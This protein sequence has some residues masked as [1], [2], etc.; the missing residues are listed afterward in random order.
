MPEIVIQQTARAAQKLAFCYL[1]GEPFENAPGRNNH[2][3]HIPPKQLFA[4][5]DRNFPIKVA[6][7]ESCNNCLSN[8][9]EVIGQLVAVVHGKYATPE[10]LKLEFETVRAETTGN[11]Y[12]GVTG[13]NVEHEVIRWI[14][15]FH[16]ALYGEF[17]ADQP[18]CQFCVSLPFPRLLNNKALN[19][20]LLCNHVSFVEEIKKN[21]HAGRLDRIVANNHQC[22]Y[23]CVWS[24][25]D[26]GQHVCIFALKLY[27]WSRL[28]DQ[29]LNRRSCVG[30][31]L[32]A[33]GR[34][35]I[36]TPA[37]RLEMPMSHADL[38]DAFAK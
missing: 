12:F 24:K 7:H 34:P 15:G 14:R 18:D 38:L 33:N 22:V 1:C 6:C 2:P 35:E 17:L 29:R 10:R 20:G 25:S 30:L 36:A 16:A 13:V 26:D 8:R 9:D 4:T 31:Y 28:A 3:D 21:R 32:P 19:D 23:E 11:E 27:D 37:T 5:R